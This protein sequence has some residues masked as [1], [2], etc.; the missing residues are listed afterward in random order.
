M[1]WFLF[2]LF[3]FPGLV[4]CE[5][6]KVQNHYHYFYARMAY[7]KKSMQQSKTPVTSLEMLKA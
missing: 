3:F 7:H 4:V 2:Y 6:V 1:L 5:A